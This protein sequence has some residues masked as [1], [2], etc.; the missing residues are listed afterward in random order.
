[1]TQASSAAWGPPPGGARTALA[2]TLP[3][4]GSVITVAA[5][6]AGNGNLIV[7]LAPIGVFVGLALV[8]TLPLRIPLMA[9]AFLSLA[10]DAADEGP[11]N[12][13][14]AGLGSL[15]HVNLAKAVPGTG[16]PFPGLMLAFAGLL[17]VHLHRCFAGVRTDIVGRQP[18][19][20]IQLQSLLASLVA[21]F[22]LCALGRFHGGDMKMAK[23]QVQTF[24][25]IL[26]VAY[27]V[28][29]TFRSVADYR[30]LGVVIIAAACVKAIIAMYVIHIVVPADM[31]FATTHGDSLLFATATVLLVVQFAE[32]PTARTAAVAVLLLPLLVHGMIDN[33]RRLVWVQILGA[34]AVFW[35]M[36]RRSQLKRALVSLML[37]SLPLLVAY[38]G[39]GWNSN[40][41]IFKP[42][43][44]LRSVGDSQVDAS[45][46]YRDLENFNLLQTQKMNLLAGTGFGIPFIEVVKLPDISFFEEYRYMPHNSILGL[47]AFCGPFGFTA[48]T[49]ALVVS[50]Y[51]AAR[52]Y[53]LARTSDE[54]I[55]AFMVIGIITIYMVHCWGDIGFTERKAVYLLG[56][57]LALAGQLAL[58]TGAWRDRTIRQF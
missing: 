43:Q 29:T 42:V 12:S 50:I 49:F 20:V 54:R 47:W 33:D 52:S 18:A 57:A 30:R 6:V 22:A 23:I 34:L 32:R 4:V 9:F 19:A 56:P 13:P 51:L 35:A 26:F 8:R 45:T 17:L 44:T 55:A 36:S 5:I 10:I 38:V 16:V 27:L 15:L 24:V 48:L 28:A 3:I 40:K 46:L 39:A 21:V 58:S 37:C 53:N 11:W 1:V 41:S 2:L 7:A 25:L 31:S 14:L